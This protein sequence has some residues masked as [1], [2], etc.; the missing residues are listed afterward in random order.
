MQ[1][2]VETGEGL[3]RRMT[4]ALPVDQIE[5]EVEKRLREMAR[6]ARLAGFRPG[7]VPV[8]VLRQRYQDQVQ[9]E[10]LADLISPTFSDAISQEQLSPAATP[11]IEP[12]LDPAAGRFGYTATFEVLPSFEP[13]GLSGKTVK[14]PRVEVTEA[15]VDEV[16]KRLRDQRKAWTAVERPAQSGDRVTVDYEGRV[17]GEPFEGGTRR[18]MAIELGTGGSMPGFEEGLLGVVPGDERAVTQEFPAD[19]HA[20][21]LQGKTAEFAVVVKGVEEPQVPEVDAEFVRS[22][23]IEDGDIEH[24]RRDVRENLERERRRRTRARVTAQVMDAL[25]EVNPIPVPE[26]MVKNEIESLKRQTLAAA[27]GGQGVELPDHLFADAARR[28]V[29]LGLILGEVVQRNNLKADPERVRA[30]VEEHAAEYESPGEV[31]RYYYAD[32][33]RLE[34]MQS[35]ALEDA[36]V[37]WALDQ[38]NV[39]D[40]PLSFQE[41]SR[42]R[43]AG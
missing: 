26:S 42:D 29:A 15:D 34:P 35:R 6:T 28:R 23:G 32:P 4:V 43:P 10:V 12:E 14:Q 20:T 18:D 24:F 11:Q 13:G 27:G 5:S 36:V 2:S 38:L 8:K 31:V 3:K 30:A 21:A 16:L 39:E 41:L 17:D 25:L 37:D 1:V 19:H 22:F 7:K 9:R 40:E 33:K